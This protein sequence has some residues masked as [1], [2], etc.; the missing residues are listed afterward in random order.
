MAPCSS[1]CVSVAFLGLAL[2]FLVSHCPR[3]QQTA[4]CNF[5]PNSSPVT[6]CWG[7][8]HLSLDNALFHCW[9]LEHG[10]HV[11]AHAVSNAARYAHIC[12]S[13]LRCFRW[14]A[15]FPYVWYGF[16]CEA[17][18]NPRLVNSESASLSNS[19]VSHA[20]SSPSI[21][22]MSLRRVMLSHRHAVRMGG[23]WKSCSFCLC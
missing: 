6:R 7:N 1:H 11:L 22:N 8:S 5:C 18:C 4:G 14:P 19:A 21:S 9:I 3:A 16:L 20:V 23:S 10:Q 2:E 13:H 12:M 17:H 15:L